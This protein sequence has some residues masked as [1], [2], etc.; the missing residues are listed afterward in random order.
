MVAV[1]VLLIGLQTVSGMAS[2]DDIIF[3]GPLYG[4]LPDWLASPLERVHEPLA[5]LLL[6]LALLHVAV[7]VVYLVWKRE[8]LVRAMIL[9]GARLPESVARAAAARGETTGAPHWRALVCAAVAAAPPLAI[10]AW[11]G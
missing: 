7:I 10:H 11:L 2:T 5:N 3:E 8:N 9:G 4:R 1:L 6:A